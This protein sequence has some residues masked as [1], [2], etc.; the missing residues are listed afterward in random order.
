MNARFSESWPPELVSGQVLVPG[1][2]YRKDFAFGEEHP[3]W[4]YFFILNRQPLQDET[5]IVCTA[6]TKI[7]KSLKNWRW[8]RQTI[9]VVSRQE[10]PSLE[11][12]SLVNCNL[13]AKKPRSELQQEIEDGKIAPLAPLPSLILA[14]LRDAV[15]ASVTLEPWVKKLVVVPDPDRS[16]QDP[17]APTA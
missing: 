10:Y 13:A 3:K 8:G 4:R 5:L 6:T 17:T 9:V 16:P 11:T 7:K 15:K 14:R 1:G 2:A 12:R